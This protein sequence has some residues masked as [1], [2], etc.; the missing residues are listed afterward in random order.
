MKFIVSSFKLLKELQSLIGVINTNNVLP[1]L[2]NFLLNLKEGNL[3]ITASDLEITMIVQITV[4]SNESG[5]ITIPARLMVNVLKTFPDQPLTI[6]IENDKKKLKIISQQGDYTLSIQNPEEFPRAPI[7]NSPTII[8][9]STNIL[10]RIINKTLFAISTDEFR[11]V[12]NGVFFDL[13]PEGSTFVSTDSHKLVKYFRKDVKVKKSVQFILPKKPLVLLKNILSNI[14]E[15]EELIIEY[16]KINTCFLFKN[17]ILI[18]SLI[19]GTYPNYKLVIPN[20]NDKKLIIHRISFLNSIKRLSL[21]SNKNTRQTCLEITKNKIKIIAEDIDF[22]NKAHEYINCDYNGKNITI[23]FNSRFLIEMLSHLSTEDIIFEM[24]HPN[25]AIILKPI[26]NLINN[27][28]IIML[29]MP[30]VI[31]V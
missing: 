20:Q 24:S 26:N 22:S 28:K 21:F 15:T 1:I 31:Q 13:T 14:V 19:E 3:T 8:N 23:A 18:C 12:M 6:F 27:E 29:V 11:P 9:L 16:N 4:N 25:C 17:K 5:E 10:L 7:L 2:D 30:I